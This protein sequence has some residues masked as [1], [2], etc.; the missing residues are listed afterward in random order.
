[1]TI[2][3]FLIK[4]PYG[5]SG[6]ATRFEEIFTQLH[7]ALG[8]STLSLE[9][10]SNSSST[11]FYIS[12]DPHAL[13]VAQAHIY[14]VVPEAIMLQAPDPLRDGESM[15]ASSVSLSRSELLPLKT[16]QEID[17]ES[18]SGIL[19]A[20]A[21][22]NPRSGCFLQI[23]MRPRRDTGL[24]QASLKAKRFVFG[25]KRMAWLKYWFKKEVARTFGAKIQQKISSR[26][27]DVSIHAGVI[28]KEKDGT[29][30]RKLCNALLRS[31]TS[32]STLDY[33]MIG[34]RHLPEK[35]GPS[36]VLS[37]LLRG[38]VLLSVKELATWY[39]FPNESEAPNVVRVLSTRKSPPQKLITADHPG[40]VS[41]FGRTNFRNQQLPFGI[42]ALDR[43]RHM[44]VVGKSGSGKSKLLE[45]LVKSDLKQGGGLAVLDPHGDL[46]DNI[47]RCIP[48]SRL[49][50]V[51]IFD[52][53]DLQFP[54]SF[55]PLEKVPEALKMRVTIGLIEIFKKLFGTN[56]SPRLEHVLRYTVLALLDNE[57]TT[58]L[59]ILEMLTNKNYRQEMV[60]NIKDHVVKNFWVNEF[61]GWSEKFDAEA[62]TPLVN[63]VGQ[64][65][66][67][68]MI[69][70]IV[71]QPVN[72]F[73][74]RSFMDTKK[75]V[76]MKISKGLLGDE[77][78]S[79]LGAMV[80]TKI[81]QAAMSRAD[82]DERERIPFS[83]Y[84][85]EF[86][87]FATSTFGEMLSEARK[88]GLNLILANQFL[89][90]LDQGIRKTVFGNV[91]T[92]VSFRLGSEDAALMAEEF[93]PRFQPRDI[94][95]LG[96]REFCMKMTIQG[97]MS[98]AFS[99]E[100]IDMLYPK[101]DL[102]N[103]IVSQSRQ[104]YARPLAE[105]ERVL[106][107]PG[108]KVVQARAANEKVFE[109]P[110]V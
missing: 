14:G 48:E 13:E 86:H 75:I 47:L 42:E 5:N 2:Q 34:F 19:S 94:I 1:M 92:L 32:L 74:F 90:Q 38:S 17:G 20:L 31:L 61:A 106:A 82:L 101:S 63:K 65:V 85:D 83:L 73:N 109:E 33:N 64:F 45:L 37:R 84:V 58:V 104:K 79:L 23:V 16:F 68:N 56:W 87:N 15:I 53:S 70:N 18:L 88:Y 99:A 95:N 4:V 57:N 71:G 103:R 51:V 26:L 72:Q 11:A 110:L 52:P 97:Q 21:K 49:K 3:S 96:V 91:G 9:I 28:C 67:T 77:N 41:L 98:E 100:T 108:L 22:C 76:L 50:D 36:I 81:F 40:S 55:N 107:A 27:Y 69:R 80:I 8:H 7:E 6:I 93:A 54:A 78:A 46:V 29:P 105:V 43:Q 102:K 89:G 12:G 44:Y 60:R 66:S 10:V 30:D 62:I 25:L 24:L 39:H 59:S 35:M